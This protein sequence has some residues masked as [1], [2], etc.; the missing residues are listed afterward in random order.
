[1]QFCFL[2]MHR[3]SYKATRVANREL[4]HVYETLGRDGY[5]FRHLRTSLSETL[6]ETA[7]SH[8]F[9]NGLNGELVLKYPGC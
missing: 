2:N 1:M 7:K 8:A 6:F 5:N 4:G 3:S 9:P